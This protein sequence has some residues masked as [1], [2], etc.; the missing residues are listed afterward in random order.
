MTEPNIAEAAA[1]PAVQDQPRMIDTPSSAAPA[2]SAGAE[3]EDQSVAE[4]SPSPVL[5]LRNVAPESSV[6]FT[7]SSRVCVM[8]FAECSQHT[9]LA[10]L[11]GCVTVSYAAPQK[12][13]ARIL[14]MFS[15]AAG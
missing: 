7:V 10:F 14:G 5:H 6:C 8:A 4:G 11:C 3:G 13:S 9:Y 1:H 2:Q 12:R 15:T